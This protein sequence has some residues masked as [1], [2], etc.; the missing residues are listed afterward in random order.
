MPINEATLRR[1]WFIVSPLPEV[2]TNNMTV[3]VFSLTG[4]AH[5]RL[6]VAGSV[7][8]GNVGHSGVP[9]QR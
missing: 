9:M 3:E 7:Q 8:G 5:E 1:G 6:D 4:L 2:H